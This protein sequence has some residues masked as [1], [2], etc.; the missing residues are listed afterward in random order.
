MATRGAITIQDYDNE[1]SVVQV[2]LADIGFVGATYATETQ[3]LDE[4]KDAI[5]G[6]ILGEVRA[7]AITKDFPESSAVVAAQ[8]AQRE[9]KWLVRYRDSSQ[10]MDVANTIPNPG[11]LK[12][13]TFEI[14]TANLAL[15]SPDAKDH[16]I[17]TAGAG[18]TLKNSLEANY[19]SPYGGLI[20]VLEI[21]HVG[22][23]N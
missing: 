13:F 3:N 19:R 12:I 23:N 22:R 9:N 14:P 20:S 4:V 17:I 7:T 21:V 10:F 8:Q 2:N 15:L 16:M 6:V 11:Y 1:K 18:L 5:I